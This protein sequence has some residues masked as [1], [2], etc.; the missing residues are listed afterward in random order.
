MA[1]GDPATEQTIDAAAMLR[2]LEVA[3]HLAG[4][5]E[6]ADLLTQVIDAGRGVAG[7]TLRQRE[8]LFVQD[9]VADTRWD[10]VT[11][12]LAGMSLRTMYCVPLLLHGVVAGVGGQVE[13]LDDPDVATDEGR[14]GGGR[15]GQPE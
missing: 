11:G 2:V 14:G 12:E 1:T 13:D 15:A 3:R 7:Y 9:V 5:F 8:P 4:P 6:L 10:R